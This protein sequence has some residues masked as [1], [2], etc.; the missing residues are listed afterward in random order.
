MQITYYDKEEDPN[1]KM[2][3]TFGVYVKEWDWFLNNIAIMKG[4]KGG[5]FLLMPNF[6]RRSSGGWEK[7]V[8]FGKETQKRFTESARKALEQYAKGQGREL[9]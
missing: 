2:L 4:T 8:E 1:S 9:L 3:A 6:K 5:W 7:T